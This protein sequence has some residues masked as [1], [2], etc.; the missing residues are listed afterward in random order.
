[1]SRRSRQSSRATGWARP[2]LY[3]GAPVSELRV[4]I[5]VGDTQFDEILG[6]AAARLVGDLLAHAAPAR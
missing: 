3:L 4:Q 5:R 1:M 6:G 2:R